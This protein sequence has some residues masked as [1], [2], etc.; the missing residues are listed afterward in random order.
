MS[1]ASIVSAGGARG[2]AGDLVGDRERLVGPAAARR[3]ARRDDAER[4]LVPAARVAAIGAER[5]GGPPQVLGG[6]LVVAAHQRH[7]RERVVDGA[8]GLVELHGAADVERAVQ[9][10]VGACRGAQAHADLTERRERPRQAGALTDAF[11][12]G[13]RPF[14]ERQRLLVAVADQRDV[15]L[16]AVHHRQ[17]VVGLDGGRQAL[18]LA[19][20]RGRFV[21]AAR[22]REHRRRERV[23]LREVAPIAGCV[24]G[25]RGFRDMLADDGEVADLAVALAEA[26]V[27]ETD[28]PRIV[29]GLGLLQGAAVQGDGARLLATREGDAAV[30]RARDLR[31]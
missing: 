17:D 22:L 9:H 27:G 10:G 3:E 15:G 26:E 19:Q 23:H 13:D 25:R 11:M 5:L 29:G 20:R 31:E 7:L 2:R 4:P 8:G 14:G 18:G 6:V 1:S 24:Q 21:V 16:V 12:H 28:G 30:Q